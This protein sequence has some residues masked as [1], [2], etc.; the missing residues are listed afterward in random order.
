MAKNKKS[1]YEHTFESQPQNKY[2]ITT[3]SLFALAARNKRNS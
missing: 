2:Y 3:G 1:K